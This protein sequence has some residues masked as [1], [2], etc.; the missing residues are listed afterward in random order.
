MERRKEER[1]KRKEERERLNAEFAKSAE[2]A[3]K[4]RKADRETDVPRWRV[5][6]RGYAA[7]GSVLCERLSGALRG[8]KWALSRNFQ[9]GWRLQIVSRSV[10]SRF[11]EAG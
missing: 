9:R 3:E 10:E 1:G 11:A 8:P 4:R 7:C 6:L 2:Y 5:S